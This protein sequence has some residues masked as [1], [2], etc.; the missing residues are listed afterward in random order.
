MAIKIFTMCKVVQSSNEYSSH[1]TELLETSVGQAGLALA[2]KAKGL[3]A[4][5]SGPTLEI[6]IVTNRDFLTSVNIPDRDTC[7]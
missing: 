5:M 3:V 6:C 1:V 2:Y 4:L 7:N